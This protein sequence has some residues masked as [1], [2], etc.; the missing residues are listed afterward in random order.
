M[1][2]F[3]TRSLWFSTCELTDESGTRS[4][5]IAHAGHHIEP[6][7]R[8]SAPQFVHEPERSHSVRFRRM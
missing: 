6:R 8:F 5:R 2:R 1:S 4:S 7:L 3:E